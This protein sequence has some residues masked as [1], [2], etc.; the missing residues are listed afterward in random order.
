MKLYF[1]KTDEKMKLFGL[2]YYIIKKRFPRLSDADYDDACSVGFLKI[3]EILHDRKYD[4]KKSKIETFICVC[5]FRAIFWE[6]IGKRRPTLYE[7]DKLDIVE[8]EPQTR[9]QIYDRWNEVK[10]VL[11]IQTKKGI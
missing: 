6:L 11:Y 3:A 4:N 5:V 9:Y 2:V 10:K 8:D 1:D 7:S